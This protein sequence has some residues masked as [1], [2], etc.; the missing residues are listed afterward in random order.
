M[1]TALLL[2][3]D[4]CSSSH[5]CIQFIPRPSP[6]DTSL[7]LT[8]TIPIPIILQPRHLHLMDRTYL[9]I[10]LLLSL[11]P[12]RLVLSFR[13]LSYLESPRLWRVSIPCNLFAQL[14]CNNLPLPRETRKIKHSVGI[15]SYL[16]K[17]QAR[18]LNKFLSRN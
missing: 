8:P 2:L 18:L 9:F 16:E 7:L 5:G 11:L 12:R 1:S 4:R 14:E 13:V 3:R 17:D 15:C 6:M 10:L